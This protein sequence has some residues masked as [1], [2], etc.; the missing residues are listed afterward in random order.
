[1]KFLGEVM[2]VVA[3]SVSVVRRSLP[4]SERISGNGHMRDLDSKRTGVCGI[5]AM[6]ATQGDGQPTINAASGKHTPPVC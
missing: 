2:E 4:R 1:M 6:V 5:G 3:F